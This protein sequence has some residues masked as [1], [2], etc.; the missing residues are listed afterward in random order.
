[1]RK[2]IPPLSHPV[3]AS[4]RVPG[5]KSLTN[6]ALICASLAK[7]ESRIINPSDSD[8]TALMINGLNQLGVLVRKSDRGLVVEGTGGRLYAPKF[9]IPVGNAGTTLRFMLSLAALAHGTTIFEG[10]P[11]MAERPLEEL[12]Q[13]LSDLG[14]NVDRTVEQS[15]YAVQGGTFKGGRTV[16]NGERSSQF[17]SSLLLASPYA[18]HDVVIDVTGKLSSS[19][20]IYLT[21][22]VMT[23]FGVEVEKQG[24]RRFLTRAGQRY[25]PASFSVEADASSASYFFAAAAICGGEVFVEGIER[26]S[27]QGDVQF[28]NVLEQMGCL[29]AAEPG[30]V[31][32]TSS[33]V[34]RGVDV[35]MNSLPDAVPALA[36]TA[37]FAQEPTTI[38]N[39]SHLHYK[40]SDRVNALV[41]ELRKLGANIQSVEDRIEIR[42]ARLTGASLDTHD[43]HRLAMSF[44]LAGLKLEGVAVENPDCVRKSFP[45]FWTEFEKLSTS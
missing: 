45:K 2:K 38:R 30:G 44:A 34:L 12:Q 28:L 14:V 37:L 8:D 29:V 11:R 39:I 13:S 27:L 23:K 22:D 18:G 24:D 7:G 10:S 26:N 21:L 41:T 6:R 1:M 4:I 33:G 5:S 42:P 17:L 16:L 43:D 31:R 25:V 35:E 36:V 15:R 40:E 19:S 3:R 20:Y 9:P 32:L